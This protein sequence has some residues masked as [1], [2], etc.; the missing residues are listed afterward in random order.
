MICIRILYKQGICF[1]ITRLL[2]TPPKVGGMAAI[3]CTLSRVTSNRLDNAEIGC[4]T[5][6]Q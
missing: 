4:E 3:S 6:Q 1:L 2:G 5:L